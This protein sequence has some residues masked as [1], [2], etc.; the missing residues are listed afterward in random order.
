VTLLFAIGVGATGC[1]RTPH[2][3]PQAPTTVSVSYPVEKEV[4]YFTEFT[5]RTAAVDSVDVRSHVWGYL[6]KIK[7]KE[8]ALVKKDEILFEIDPRPYVA[9]VNQAKADLDS[10]VAQE[11]KTFAVFKRTEALVKDKA[12]SKEDL[13]NARGDWGVAKANI[14]LSKANLETAELNLK[15]TKVQAQISGR[16]GKY[17]VTLGNIVQSGDQ[18][19]GTLLTTIVSVDPMYAYFDV[20]E[21]TVLHVKELIRQGKAKSARDDESRWPVFLGLASENGLF[22]HRGVINYV[23][24]QVNASTGTLQLRGSFPNADEALT[25]GLFVRVRVPVGQPYK[26]ILISDRAIDSDQGQK[27]V[28]VVDS[29]NEVVV[30]PVEL[31][32]LHDGLREI[33]SGLKPQERVIVNGLQQVRPG[34]VVEPKEVEM[35]VRKVTR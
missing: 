21:R 20:D 13:D 35:P 4:S 31:G 6:D 18:G 10:K 27:I 15:F 33:V 17:N 28:Y 3:P 26:A 14:E 11:I 16:I 12:A 23:G 34:A 24:N 19:G 22:P 8:G 2:T 1:T 29:K 32:E 25:P 9:L 7:F 30:H 5:G